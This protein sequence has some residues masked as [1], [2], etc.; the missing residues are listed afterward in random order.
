MGCGDRGGVVGAVVVENHDSVDECRQVIEGI[1]HEQGLIA[2][3]HHPNDSWMRNG[4]R[5][6]HDSV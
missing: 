5:T 2:H 3:P 1:P 4:S 6:S